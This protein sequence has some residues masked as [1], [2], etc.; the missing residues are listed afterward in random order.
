MIK[1][2]NICLGGEERREKRDSLVCF[3]SF[4][5]LMQE[6]RNFYK[7]PAIENIYFVEKEEILELHTSLHS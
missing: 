1:Y 2:L 7:E 6:I 5:F 3:H 4:I